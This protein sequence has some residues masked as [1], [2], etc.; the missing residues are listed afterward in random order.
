MLEF[1]VYSL[2]LEVRVVWNRLIVNGKYIVAGHLYMT[3]IDCTMYQ[4][5][6]YHDND[7]VSLKVSIH[8]SVQ[9]Y[10]QYKHVTMYWTRTMI[11]QANT[12][13]KILTYEGFPGMSNICYRLHTIYHSNKKVVCSKRHLFFKCSS[14]FIISYL[15]VAFRP[16][17]PVT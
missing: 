10:R 7:I 9:P 8:F 16:F 3:T 11:M 2:N 13:N 4:V 5:L 15:N 17:F 14:N 1:T 12:N 6:W